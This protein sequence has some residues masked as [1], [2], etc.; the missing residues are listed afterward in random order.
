[1]SNF[2]GYAIQKV[3]DIAYASARHEFRWLA[4][5]GAAEDLL[6]HDE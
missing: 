5:G 4:S 3:S 6:Q 2:D 1:M